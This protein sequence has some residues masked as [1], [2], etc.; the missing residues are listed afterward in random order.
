MKLHELSLAPGAKKRRIRVGR[1]DGSNRGGTAGR[2]HKGQKSRSGAALRTQFEGGQ[3]PS[4]RRIP[5]VGFKR[6]CVKVVFNIVN[7]GA[8]DRAFEAG[9]EVDAR[10]MKLA[11]VL[12]KRKAPLKIL[13]GGEITKA[14][15]VTADYFSA[16][17]REKIEKAGGSC[18]VSAPAKAGGNAASAT[19]EKAGGAGESAAP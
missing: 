18:T 13:G 8:L 1:G 15:K 6:H 4:F 16:A 2:G 14:L 10:A 17:A 5:K 12:C 3:T 19:A 7:V 9:A 11:G